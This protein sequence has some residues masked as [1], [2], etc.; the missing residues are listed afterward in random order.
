MKKIIVLL[1]CFILFGCSTP[2]NTNIDAVETSVAA[3]ISQQAIQTKQAAPTN[4]LMPSSTPRPTDTPIPV[5]SPTPTDDPSLFTIA[6]NFLAKVEQYGVTFEISRILIADIEFCK[7][8]IPQG[9]KY[10]EGAQSCIEVVCTIKNNSQ[11]AVDSYMNSDLISFNG[12]QISVGEYLYKT[13]VDGK[14]DFG[15]I[16]PGVS[17]TR[18][19]WIPFKNTKFNQPSNL[20]INTGS[21]V[22]MSPFQILLKDQLFTFDTTGWTFEPAPPE[23]FK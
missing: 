6:K 1:F 23:L 4:T 2:Q 19:Y 14:G 7:S 5:A 8:K 17:M 21:V 11:D 16:L 3:T 22:K 9:S 10:W 12:E 20:L 18:G 15:K 13:S